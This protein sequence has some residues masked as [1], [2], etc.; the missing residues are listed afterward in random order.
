MIFEQLIISLAGNKKKQIVFISDGIVLE[1]WENMMINKENEPEVQ[2]L[3][4]A[5]PRG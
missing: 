5:P 3:P 1:R 2:N 4:H